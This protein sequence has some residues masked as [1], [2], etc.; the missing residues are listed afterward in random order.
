MFFPLIAEQTYSNQKPKKLFAKL[1]KDGRKIGKRIETITFFAEKNKNDGARKLS[2]KLDI[3]K[4]PYII[5]ASSLE[6]LI[7]FPTHSHG[8]H[9]LGMHE[10]FI[11]P[12]A[13]G[14]EQNANL[15]IASYKYFI[16]D[17]NA[18][19]LQTILNG[20]VVELTEKQLFPKAKDNPNIYCYREVSPEFEAIKMAYDDKEIGMDSDMRFIQ[21]W[22]KGDDYV[23][24]NQY[25]KG[26]IMW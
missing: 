1:L 26:G 18:K 14:P 5:H 22:I 16:R 12:L 4:Y 2:K 10:M 25:F 17:K 11:D 8:L 9:D 6:N 13:F 15:I 19:M 21:I 7:L 20:E 24:S 23:L 3:G